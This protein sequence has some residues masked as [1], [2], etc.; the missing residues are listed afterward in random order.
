MSGHD[1]RQPIYRGDW[2]DVQARYRIATAIRNNH[3]HGPWIDPFSNPPRTEHNTLRNKPIDRLSTFLANP[4]LVI[5][6]VA[7]TLALASAA[8]F[9]LIL[10]LG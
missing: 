1:F 3:K 4:Y 2:N 7:G 5:S 6:S 9:Y 8:A 10:V